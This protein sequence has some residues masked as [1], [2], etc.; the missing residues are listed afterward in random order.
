[1]TF[2]NACLFQIRHLGTISSENCIDNG[3]VFHCKNYAFETVISNVCQ[4]AQGSTCSPVKY[5]ILTATHT[6]EHLCLPRYHWGLASYNCQVISRQATEYACPAVILC[7]HQ[8]H[9]TPLTIPSSVTAAPAWTTL[10]MSGVS[11]P[12]PYACVAKSKR[13]HLDEEDMS[14]ATPAFIWNWILSTGDD[15][16][17][18]LSTIYQSIDSM[19]SNAAIELHRSGL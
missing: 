13:V 15:M 11:T 17:L 14:L 12:M 9:S 8:L 1:M 19:G 10:R 3:V 2:T 16:L 5:H 6:F 18:M 7:N 4:F